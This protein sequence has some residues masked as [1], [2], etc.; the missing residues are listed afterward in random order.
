[1]PLVVC[2]RVYP[3]SV[4]LEDEL[5][6]VMVV[7]LFRYIDKLAFEAVFGKALHQHQ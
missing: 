3:D 7:N 5:I 1:M 6:F 2:V 4:S